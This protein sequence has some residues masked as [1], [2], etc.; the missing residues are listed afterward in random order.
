MSEFVECQNCGRTFFAAN[1][2]CPYCSRASRADD[3]D[4]DD[5]IAGPGRRRA[6]IVPVRRT[7][8]GGGSAMFGILFTTFILVLGGVAALSFLAMPRSPAGSP[9]T[10]LGMEA[11]GAVVTLVGLVQR[12]RWG[13]WLAILFILANATIGLLA[14]LDRG[15]GR[16]LA[17]GPGPAAMLLFLLPFLSPQAR[18]RYTR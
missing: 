15:Q 10:L 9:R 5:E 13:R 8:T 6:R 3:D 2:D 14:L 18:D 1:I 16:S 11:A 7:R 12:R 4:D 17:W